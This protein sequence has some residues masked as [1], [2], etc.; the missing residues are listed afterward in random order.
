[1][2][3]KMNTLQKKGFIFYLKK[4]G[5][6]YL[7]VAPFFI[8]FAIFG[9]YPMF[10]SLYLSFTNWTPTE[11]TF[12]GLANFERMMT[13]D[14][15]WISV[16]NTFYLFLINVPLMT[17]MAIIFAYM[18]NESFL[19]GRR[20]YQLLYL[21]PYVTSTVAIGIVF[22]VLFDDSHGMINA[23]LNRL[24]LPSVGWFRSENAAMWLVNILII[25]Q[26]VGYN[27]LLLLGGLQS[28]DTNLYEAAFVDGSNRIKNLFYITIPHLRPVIWF[29]LI[30]S[31]MGT[32]N[33]IVPMLILHNG[34]PGYAT[35]VMAFWQYR[36][37]FQNFRLGYGAA[38]GFAILV[39]TLIFT[40]PQVVRAIRSED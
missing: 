6:S 12:T 19:K 37:T 36:Q 2:I 23:A 16:K 1:M 7:F 22:R 10:Y 27:M 14:V 11:I 39:I 29:C 24:N 35:H 4:Y 40:I 18:F 3:I 17:L 30:M 15:W 21:L 28:I 5:N 32:F 38:L 31:T 9:I 25:W 33:A 20:I 34:G 13:D 8:I 26:W